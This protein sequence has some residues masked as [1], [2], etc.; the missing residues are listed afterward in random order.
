VR[1]VSLRAA[2]A[3]FALLAAS[4]TADAQTFAGTTVGGPTWNR[5]VQ[6]NPPSSLSGI[7]S[8]VAYDVIGFRVTMSGAY[9]LLS[10]ALA[11]TNWDNF[12]HLY[13]GS[14]NATSPFVNV[15]IGNDDFPSFGLAGF[16]GLA[17]T[18]G[19]DYFAVTSGFDNSNAGTYELSISGPGTAF[20]PGASVPEP[21]SMALLLVGGVALFVP[22]RRRRQA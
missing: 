17:L 8:N 14:F 19:V 1:S 4:S 12:L 15:I 10:T 7:G 18:A 16:N 22:A 11:P 3:V 2:A 21:A 13:A 6:G 5:P 9:D 20:T